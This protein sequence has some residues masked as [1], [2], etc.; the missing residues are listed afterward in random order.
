[1]G[2][3]LFISPELKKYQKLEMTAMKW[4]EREGVINP[5]QKA[6]LPSTQG[7]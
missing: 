4:N 1:V 3:R 7:I 5:C 2:K 6:G